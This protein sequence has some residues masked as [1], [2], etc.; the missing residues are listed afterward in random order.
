MIIVL[1]T[2]VILE[3]LH[4][5]VGVMMPINDQRIRKTDMGYLPSD[6]ETLK[7][8]ILRLKDIRDQ[9]RY[10]GDNQLHIEKFW[11][12][13]NPRSSRCWVCDML[14]LLDYI[15]DLMQSLVEN[16]PHHIWKAVRL[17]GTQDFTFKPN[18][19]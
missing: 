1:Q 4:A 15:I 3:N 5:S 17:E 9:I 13:V 2:V 8:Y 12:H 10:G 11:C 16:D 7:G 18:R 14:D 19:K 6:K